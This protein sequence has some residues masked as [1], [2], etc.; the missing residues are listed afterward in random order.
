MTIGIF[1]LVKDQT[2]G[3]FIDVETDSSKML[4]GFYS[5]R[6]ALWGSD[7]VRSLGLV[8]LPKLLDI[9]D[10]HLTTHDEFD[11][12]EKEIR[13]IEKNIDIIAVDA[14][15]QPKYIMHYVK[16]ALEAI[17][18]ARELNGTIMIG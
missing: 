8:L 6:G 5:H 4:F 7:L 13:I 1:V 9:G 17:S 2:T 11:L 12:F 10:L 3:E 14:G 15:D 16:N 18:K